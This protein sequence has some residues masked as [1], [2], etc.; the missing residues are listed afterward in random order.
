[1]R[2]AGEGNMEE[3]RALVSVVERAAALVVYTEGKA[4]RFGRESSGFARAADA[5]AE[6]TKEA[7]PMPAF[8]VSIDR[9][10][11][12]GMQK[13]VWAEF[14]FA[15]EQV[16]DGMPFTA[17]LFEVRAEYSGFNLARLQDGGY[18]GRCFYLDLRGGTMRPFAEAL[19]GI[20][21]K[22]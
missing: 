1:M 17:L 16:L 12:E 14:V 11:R 18:N 13:G 8:G 7:L 6:M 15:Q 5:W 22:H 21:E 20:T 10:A 4:V 9:L 19:A 3:D 2:A